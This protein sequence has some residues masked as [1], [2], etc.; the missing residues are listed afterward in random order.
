MPLLAELKQSYNTILFASCISD[1]SGNCLHTNARWQEITGLTAEQSAGWGWTRNIH[2][3]DLA[4]M[5]QQLPDFFSAKRPGVFHYRIIDGNAE[6]HIQMLSTPVLSGT[7]VQYYVCILTDHSIQKQQEIQIKKQNE[8][9][10]VLQQIQIGF[11]TSDNETETFESLL[12]NILN[13]TG[14]GIGFIGEMVEIRPGK[15][16]MQLRSFNIHALEPHATAFYDQHRQSPLNFGDFDNLFGKAITSGEPLISNN[17]HEDPRRKGIPPGHP[18][19]ENFLGLPVRSG[20]M[21]IGLIGLANKKGGF[22]REMISF[23]EPLT[24]TVSTLLQ[25]N[26]IKKEKRNS[27]RVILENAQYLQVLLASL[28]DIVLEM[29]EKLV[30]TNVW[31]NDESKL[32]IPRDVFIGKSFTEFFDQEFCDTVM[33]LLR[34]VLTTGESAIHEYKDVRP[35][36]D[37]WFSGKY[38]L[39]RLSNGEKRILKQ[40]RDITGIKKAQLE[41]LMAK[42]AAEKAARIKSEFLSVM[43]HEIRTPMNAIIGFIDLLLHEDPKPEQLAYLD[44]LKLSAGQLLYLLNNILDYS[45]LEAGKMQAEEVLTSLREQVQFIEK[46]FSR[47]AAE[48]HITLS[49][50]VDERIPEYCKTDPFRLNRILTNLVSNAVKFTSTGNVQIS[51]TYIDES[52]ETVKV[53][54]TVSDTGVGISEEQLPFIFDEFTQEHSSTTRKYGGTGLGLT[55]TRKLVEEFGSFIEVQS[56]KSKGSVFS[57]TLELPKGKS[58]PAR[59]AEEKAESADL[60]GL[61]ILIV[62]DNMINALIVQRFI[63]NWGGRSMH[64]PSGAEAVDMV[65]QSR[66]DMILMDLQMPEMDGFEATQ[67]IRNILP[68]IPIIALTADAMAE[69]RTKVLAGG[70]DNYMTKPFNPDDLRELINLYRK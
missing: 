54:F 32:F 67:R 50:M 21:T 22:D 1:A 8:L 69:T 3:E 20:N 65:K 66:F 12:D 7:E 41:I 23:L 42:E 2:P 34:K 17:V 36:S 4:H 19:L 11:L 62:E 18:P 27:E 5:E 10:H 68:D 29:N 70:M 60:S 6:K 45:K 25:S 43:S 38:S 14:C 13:L 53:K 56:T 48:K 63:E 55:I 64:A 33:P 31:T 49:S 30:F 9:L 58:A 61:H 26:R 35:G 39:V 15:D 57:F 24:I 16:V 44:N 46:T 51:L 40:I 37:S 52:P 47:L 28:D 59:P